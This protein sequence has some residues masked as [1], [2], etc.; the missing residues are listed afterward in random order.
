MEVFCYSVE[1]NEHRRVSGNAIWLPW[2]SLRWDERTSTM[3][4]FVMALLY[5]GI[6]GWEMKLDEQ[7]NWTLPYLC[8]E[9]RKNNTVDEILSGEVKMEVHDSMMDII[10]KSSERWTARYN[11]KKE[12]NKPEEP[13]PQNDGWLIRL[14]RRW[15]MIG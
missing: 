5:A 8:T 12:D 15:G 4:R 7:G 3:M 2:W 6:S 1:V 11:K 10:R 14:M 13:H 9:G